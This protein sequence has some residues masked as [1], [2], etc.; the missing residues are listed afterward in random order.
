MWELLRAVKTEFGKF[1]DALASAKKRI[2]SVG[3]AIEGAERRTRAI[4]RK[5]RHV[6]ELPAGQSRLILGD[7]V[8]SI[9]LD[10]GLDE[11]VDDGERNGDANL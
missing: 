10:D 8:T 2:M 4:D 11:E 7:E 3:T 5:L 9:A 6:Q 1:G